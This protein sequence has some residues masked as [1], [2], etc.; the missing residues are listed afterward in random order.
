MRVIKHLLFL[1]AIAATQIVLADVPVVEGY[2]QGDSSSS[3]T[4]NSQQKKQD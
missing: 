3:Q 1:I 4:D 2:Q